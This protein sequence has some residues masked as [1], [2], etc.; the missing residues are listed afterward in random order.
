MEGAQNAHFYVPTE[1]SMKEF[2]LY[3]AIILRLH[4]TNLQG[5][6]YIYL[7]EVG[8]TGLLNLDCIMF[9]QS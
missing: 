7:S 4:W 3:P 8:I 6:S 2:W 1:A 9:S 5:F